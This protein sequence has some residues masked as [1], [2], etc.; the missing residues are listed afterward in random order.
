MITD[1]KLNIAR[2]IA[3]ASLVATEGMNL[4]RGLVSNGFG[5]TKENKAG[6]VQI[7][8]KCMA[9]HMQA[10]ETQTPNQWIPMSLM[11]CLRMMK[12]FCD[13]DNDSLIEY[14]RIHQDHIGDIIDS[15][16]ELQMLQMSNEELT[17]FEQT[18]KKLESIESRRL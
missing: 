8:L 14:A 2:E 5:I 18:Q 4:I 16:K 6:M 12:M 9:A 13:S 1:R 17:A 7:C 10:F 15:L 3:E 11:E